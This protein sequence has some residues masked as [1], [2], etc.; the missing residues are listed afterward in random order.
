MKENVWIVM[1]NIE[2]PKDLMNEKSLHSLMYLIFSKAHNG[3]GFCEGE[4]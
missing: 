1:E 3:K 2:I 4:Y